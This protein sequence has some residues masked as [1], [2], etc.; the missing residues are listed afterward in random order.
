MAKP[1]AAP[2]DIETITWATLQ[3]I[4]KEHYTPSPSPMVKQNEF[5][6]RRQKEG[7]TINNFVAR[8]R[9]LA[10][11]C[12]FINPEKMMKD[13]IILG[14]RDLTLQKKLLVRREATFK[15]VREE[16][17]IAESCDKSAADM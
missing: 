6:S 4:L 3:T 7:E 10:S 17:R 15:D 16:A 8:L 9:E 13:R 5:Y 12:E 11:E 1:L 14:M 2:T